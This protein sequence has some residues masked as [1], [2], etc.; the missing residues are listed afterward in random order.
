MDFERPDKGTGSVVRAV[1][2][3]SMKLLDPKEQVVMRM[4]YGL[5]DGE[6][7][8]LEEI[9][10]YFKVCLQTSP[11]SHLGQHMRQQVQRWSRAGDSCTL[12]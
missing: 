4:R 6:P 12:W 11:C 7:R 1:I 2:M 8:T 10:R 3:A 9:G 5:D